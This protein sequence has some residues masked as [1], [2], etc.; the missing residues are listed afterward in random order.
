MDHRDLVVVLELAVP[1]R[2]E[3]AADA[4]HAEGM[5]LG[6]AQRA[7]AGAA[8]HVDAL[9][10]RPQDL[11]VPDREHAF[12]V[13][14]D[15]PDRLRPAL[16]DPVDVPLGDRRQRDDVVV[17]RQVLRTQGRSDEHA[18][19]HRRPPTNRRARGPGT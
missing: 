10:H 1:I 13:P 9:G 19:P 18:G 12:E 16:R 5:Q 15:D 11:L 14:V 4:D 7:H 17:R 6:G 8:E 3:D 2:L